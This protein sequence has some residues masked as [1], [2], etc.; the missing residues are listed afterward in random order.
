MNPQ[1]IRYTCSSHRPILKSS[2]EFA[3]DGIDSAARLFAE[4]RARREF[5]K[6]GRVGAF[7]MDCYNRDYST[8][9]YEAFIGYP[10]GD[11]LSGRNVRFTVHA[12][13]L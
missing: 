9:E 8:V 3:D 7:R 6:S 4:R 10:C 12:E 1:R 11:G 5:G 13:T 2:L